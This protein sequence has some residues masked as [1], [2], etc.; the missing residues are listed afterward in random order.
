MCDDH[1]Q[2]DEIRLTH[3]YIAL[4]L[5]VRRPSVTTAL[6]VLEGNRFIRSERGLVTM[7]DRKAMEE[8]AGE[9]YGKPEEYYRRLMG[10]PL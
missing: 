10:A 1:I 5:A 3:E 4:M 6:H 2:G 9:A 8:F 7:R